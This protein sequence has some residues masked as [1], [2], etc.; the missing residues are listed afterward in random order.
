MAEHISLQKKARGE[1]P[2]YFAD[3]AIDKTLAITLALAGE[4]AVGS[5][6]HG[7]V[8]TVCYTLREPKIRLISARLATKKERT[9]YEN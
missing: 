9:Q 8:V 5:D 6:A 2:Q 4:V 1:R 3:P 7:R